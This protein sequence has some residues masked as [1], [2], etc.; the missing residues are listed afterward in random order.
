MS[1]ELAASAT[2]YVGHIEFTIA[3][4][5]PER[6]VSR[7]PVT[8]GIRNPF[9]T[10]HAG[11]VLWFADVTATLLAIQAGEVKPDGSGFPVALNLNANLLG[12]VREGELVATATFLRRGRRVSAVHTEVRG[13]D[14]RLLVDVTTTHMPV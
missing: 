13:P 11:A 4:K 8:D 10:V 3:E 12:N 7:M 6:V 9:G 1:V 2:H 5:S 14:G